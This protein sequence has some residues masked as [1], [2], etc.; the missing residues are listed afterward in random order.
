MAF[1]LVFVA[2]FASALTLFALQ[3]ATATRLTFLFWTVEGMSLAAV[4]LLSA[5]GGIVLVGVPLWLDR[6]RLRGQVRAL[7][8]QLAALAGPEPDDQAPPAH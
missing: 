1:K 6:W 8:A 3:N 2:V 5:A 7:A 4:I